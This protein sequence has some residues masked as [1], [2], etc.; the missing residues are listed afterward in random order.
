MEGRG[1]GVEDWRGKAHLGSS[2]PMSPRHFLCPHVM[3]CVCVSLPMSMHHCLCPHVVPCVRM[4][5]SVSV[6]VHGRSF[7]LV[8]VGG[9]LHWWVVVFVRGRS[10]FFCGQRQGV[11][12]G[13]HWLVVVGP[14]GW[15]RCVV[16][17]QLW[18][19][20][21]TRWCA[22]QLSCCRLV[23][24]SPA[25]MWHLWLVSMKRRGGGCVAYLGWA[26]PGRHHVV[27]ALWWVLDGGGGWVA[28]SM[29]VV[30]GRKKTFEPQLLHL[31]SHVPRWAIWCFSL[32]Y[33]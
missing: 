16:V 5:F 30:V 20:R 18:S 12:M 3:A 21:G 6:H 28:L 1:S 15:H 14:C 13:S 4:S 8:G 31:G 11:V 24:T 10:V 25:V 27:V 33:T 23:A 32:S 19:H 7:S 17:W 2:L 26:R 22:S 29:V 9:S